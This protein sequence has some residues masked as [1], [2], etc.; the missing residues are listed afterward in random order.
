VNTIVLGWTRNQS[1]P[2]VTGQTLYFNAGTGED[3]GT[4]LGAGV[5]S[6]TK[7]GLSD[8]T[9][10]TFRVTVKDTDG[11]ESAGAFIQPVTVLRNPANLSAVPWNGKVTLTWEDLPS[12]LLGYV[13]GYN[14]YYSQNPFSYVTGF[15]PAVRV[16]A[17]G[18]GGQAVITGLTNGVP[19]YFAVTTVNVSGGERKT[20]TTVSAA[21][22]SDME[23][24]VI[25]SIN[26]T[27]GQVITEPYTINVKVKD[28]E[29]AV[30]SLAVDVDGVNLIT[31]TSSS[32]SAFYNIGLQGAIYQNGNHSIRIR[33]ADT[34]GNQAAYSFGVMV[35]GAAPRPP[36]LTGTIPSGTVSTPTLTSV[37][38][39][40][41]E[42]QTITLL[43]NGV[44]WSQTAVVNGAGQFTFAA[45]AISEGGNELKAIAS[46]RRGSSAPSNSLYV[47][48]DTGAPG[49]PHSLKAE[50][51]AGGVVHF[52]WSPAAG[53]I[54]D[55]YH[56]YQSVSAFSSATAPGVR[57]VDNPGSP[58]TV[59]ETTYLP[60][61]D[62]VYYYAVT[63]LDESGNESPIS[64]VVSVAG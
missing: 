17:T 29:S 52:A 47:T 24:P 62:L 43:V 36:V 37:N 40:A 44:Q 20:V 28:A 3:G 60:D 41:E 33:T 15:T 32:I 4:P 22:R 8:E 19:Y 6:Y 49:G 58:I 64:N 21:P 53:E 56:L 10:Y 7:N 9:Q 26:I 1:D 31:G 2:D 25:D 39:T 12:N 5:N 27:E 61:N 30:A 46:D 16:S 59:A 48:L 63:A 45:A 42:A 57:A 38:G 14:V 55:R 13:A 50:A 18:M 23:P 51:R 34:L 35:S 11:N 54:P